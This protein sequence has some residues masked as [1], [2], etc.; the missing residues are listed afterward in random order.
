MT[1]RSALAAALV[2]IVATLAALT[3]SV[4]PV[5]ATPGSAG[6]PG[7][8]GSAGSTPLTDG[9]RVAVR[10]QVP[11]AAAAVA[12]DHGLSIVD[13][14]G[15]EG[16]FLL[17]LATGSTSLDALDDDPR[18]AEVVGPETLGMT[19]DAS[20]VFWAWGL[21]WAWGDDVRSA[22]EA[23]ADSS[24]R[25][26]V[27]VDAGAGVVVAVIDTG[28]DRSH[29]AF[30][31]VHV[32]PGYDFVDDDPYPDDTGNGRDDDGDG[33]VDE[34][35]GHGTYVTSLVAQG[36]PGV[37]ILPIRAIGDDGRT[38]TWTIARALR[39]AVDQGAD[40][41]NLSLGGTSRDRLLKRL[42][43]GYTDD[44]GVLFVAAAGNTGRSAPTFPA[45][46]DEP[47]AVGAL[48]QADVAAFSARGP[49]VDLWAPGSGVVGALPGGHLITWDGTS[50]AAAI[51]TAQAA[52]VAA[53]APFADA[54]TL[55]VELGA[56]LPAD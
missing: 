38:D 13:V 21:F 8:S 33:H 6:G 48:A 30:S 19:A 53:D 56:P 14:V 3:T 26:A 28:I 11:S 47:V 34:G 51:V 20:G 1:H 23:I 27:D 16:E 52:R 43:G 7:S 2:A 12:G 49:W 22:D 42:I 55:R 44:R 18:V 50:A 17:A 41:I 5:G 54:A 35:V 29:W 10:L 15:S 25:P 37:T 9:E 46:E 32:A 31:G 4:V 36:A 39:Y 40:I 24:W 45:A